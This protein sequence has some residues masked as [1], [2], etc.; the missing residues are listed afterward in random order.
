MC[1]NSL[2]F[3]LIPG[4]GCGY[5]LNVE[6]VT[7]GVWHQAVASVGSTRTHFLRA[8]LPPNGRIGDIRIDN[9]ALS[10]DEIKR[11]PKLSGTFKAI[12]HL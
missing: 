3:Y 1:Y 8:L 7:T 10:L 12:S 11:R 4:D 9:R 5:I 6:E 2:R